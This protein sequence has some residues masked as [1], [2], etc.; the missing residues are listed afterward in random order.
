MIIIKSVGFLKAN[1]RVSRKDF[2]QDKRCK[3]RFFSSYWLYSLI[4]H[5]RNQTLIKEQTLQ[6]PQ[7]SHLIQK[8]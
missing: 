7:K 3:M 2:Y 6:E 8:A 1:F 4:L 5:L